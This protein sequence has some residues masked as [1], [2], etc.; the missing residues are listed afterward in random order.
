MRSYLKYLILFIILVMVGMVGVNLYHNH[1]LQREKEN[2]SKIQ[3]GEKNKDSNQNEE[4]VVTKSDGTTED[5]ST[6][7]VEEEKKE[8]STSTND[9]SSQGSSSTN[10]VTDSQAVSSSGES[11]ENSNNDS[12]NELEISSTNSSSSSANM[13]EFNVLEVNPSIYGTSSVSTFSNKDSAL[14][15]NEVVVSNNQ[16]STSLS[17]SQGVEDSTSNVDENSTSD[18]EEIPLIQGVSML[19]HLNKEVMVIGSKKNVV[20]MG[21]TYPNNTDTLSV[22]FGNV[23]PGKIKW[24]VVQGKAIASVDENGV[25]SA[26]S[27]GHAVVRATLASD[28]SIYAECNVYVVHSLYEY[29]TLNKNTTVTDSYTKERI[30]LTKGQKIV[31]LDNLKRKRMNYKNRLYRVRIDDDKIALIRGSYLNFHSYYVESGYD[32]SIY[33]EYVNHNGF[34]SKT[35]YLIWVNQ[36]TQRLILFKKVGNTWKVSENMKTSTGDSEGKYTNDKGGTT[37]I[38]FDLEVRDFNSEKNKSS[39]GR[40]IHVQKEKT[41]EYFANTIHVGSLPSN[42]AGGNASE[43]APSS[44]GCPHLSRSNRDKLYQKYNEGSDNKLISSK[45]IYY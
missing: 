29:V 42:K 5:S 8:E 37:P 32:N 24:E 26:I 30:K 18:D 25:V 2:F 39:L 3:D 40:M 34:T 1:D 22:D 41:K 43:N 21:K 31:L 10:S 7:K 13:G 14:D 19:I 9:A 6:E 45:V 20:S 23:T 36:G 28:K 27:G 33:E 4:K 15:S 12:E 11:A 16:E 35:N 38:Q 44:H 17:D